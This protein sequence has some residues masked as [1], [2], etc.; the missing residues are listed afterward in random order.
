MVVRA[1]PLI[2]PVATGG[3]RKT[4]KQVEMQTPQA[5]ETGRVIWSLKQ[6][7]EGW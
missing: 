5:L 4:A 1:P 2:V 3:R 7:F 6:Y